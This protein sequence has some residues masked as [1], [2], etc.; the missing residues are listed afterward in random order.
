MAVFRK[1]KS[2]MKKIALVG[3]AS[4]AFSF[5]IGWAYGFKRITPSTIIATM[6]RRNVRNYEEFREKPRYQHFELSIP[7]PDVVFLGDSITE[8]SMFNE[9]LDTSAR[10]YNRGVSGDTAFDIINRL[11]EIKRLK[12]KVVYLMVGIND[13]NRGASPA[14]VAENISKI[15]DS[16]AKSG[17]KTIVQ[18]TIQCQ[19]PKCSLK[20]EVNELNSILASVFKSELLRMGELSSTNGLNERFTYDGVHLNKKGYE[21]WINQLLS[22]PSSFL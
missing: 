16:L 22:H 21:A 14:Q 5:G 11:H 9:S 3:I 12:P 18:E 19:P 13:L 8:A 20:D 15:H 17:I 10:I 1:S 7:N 4:I 6:L 2:Q